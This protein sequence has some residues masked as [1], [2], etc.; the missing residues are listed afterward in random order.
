MLTLAVIADGPAHGYAVLEE[1]K[2]RS[3]GVVDLPEG[4][5]YPA[6]HRLEGAGLLASDWDTSTGRKRRVYTVTKRGRSV[7]TAE[8]AEWH[9]FVDAVQ[10]VLRGGAPWPEPA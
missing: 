10:A 7:L 3:G 8:Q 6:L 1:L 5:L 4:T 9:Q 2:P